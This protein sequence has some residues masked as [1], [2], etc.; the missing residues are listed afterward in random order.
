MLPSYYEG[1]PHTILEA[2][3]F[4]LPV[5]ASDIG[6]VRDAIVDGQN[7]FIVPRYDDQT[8]SLRMRD[9]AGNPELCRTMS[10]RNRKD[11]RQYDSSVVH[12]NLVR[13][14][15]PRVL[16]EAALTDSPDCSPIAR[17][18]RTWRGMYATS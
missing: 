4:G 10:E 15:R 17:Q 18:T 14:L 5:I 11:V 1:F 2:M 3:A 13:C 8:L 7:G 12:R 6:G 16:E 9:L